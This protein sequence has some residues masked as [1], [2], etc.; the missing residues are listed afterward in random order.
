MELEKQAEAIKQAELDREAFEAM[1]KGKDMTDKHMAHT[2]HE[3][4]QKHMMEA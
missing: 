2:E 4:V 1:K 3:I